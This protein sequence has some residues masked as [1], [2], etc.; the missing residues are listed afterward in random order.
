MGRQITDEAGYQRSLEWLVK[1]AAILDDP[2]LEEAAKTKLQAQYDLVAEKVKEYRR[3]ELAAKYPG[4]KR[5]YEIL[6][7]SYQEMSRKD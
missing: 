4:L 5:Q 1:K 2:L 7:W 6:G 3:G